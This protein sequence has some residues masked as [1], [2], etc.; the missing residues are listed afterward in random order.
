MFIPIS[1]HAKDLTGRKF[2]ML[3]AIGPVKRSIAKTGAASI[4]WLCG[5]DCGEMSVVVS[6][7]LTRVSS[8]GR[9]GTKSCG[10]SHAEHTK[11]MHAMNVVHGHSKTKL[12]DTWKGMIRRCY[13]KDSD[14]YPGYGGRGITVCDRW[15]FGEDGFHG[16]ECF[17]Q[18]MGQPPS[19]R[20]SLDRIDNSSGY[21]PN[22][23]RWATLLQQMRNTRANLIVTAYGRT[24]CLSSFTGG[25]NTTFYQRVWDRIVN[26]GWSDIE[27]AIETP[28]R[29]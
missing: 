15:R 2:G 29:L 5:C 26:Q 21:R 27:S 1:N 7:E 4:S 13:V 23:C 11:K 8:K 3:K 16:V 25:A 12:H 19:R 6:N 17:L 28:G 10:C 20:H 24:A 18:D 9:V 14:A 22:N